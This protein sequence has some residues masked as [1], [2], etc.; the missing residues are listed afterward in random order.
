MGA[1]SL[2]PFLPNP[3]PFSLP[4]KLLEGDQTLLHSPATTMMLSLSM[5]LKLTM[6]GWKS[7][8]TG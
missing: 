7:A 8:D 2:S 4:P 3:H 1:Y 6:E 5:V